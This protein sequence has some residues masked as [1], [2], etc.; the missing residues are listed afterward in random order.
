[1]RARHKGILTLALR[2][3]RRSANLSFPG[4]RILGGFCLWNFNREAFP[5]R[6]NNFL[7][8]FNNF[9]GR[10][11]LLWTFGS[12]ALAR[13]FVF[14]LSSSFGFRHEASYGAGRPD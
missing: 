3:R 11:F 9:F 5:L 7:L 8:R 2:T 13:S 4:L 10:R 1:M 14:G 6:F 12:A